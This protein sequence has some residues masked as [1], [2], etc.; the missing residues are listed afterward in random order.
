MFGVFRTLRGCVKCSN[1]WVGGGYLGGRA[2]V[3]RTTNGQGNLGTHAN[4]AR[5]LCA[6]ARY[7]DLSESILC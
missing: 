3:V 7:D 6:R 2:D 5:C 4:T 1:Y